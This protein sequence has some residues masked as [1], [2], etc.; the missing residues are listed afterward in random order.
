MECENCG[1]DGTYKGTPVKEG[2]YFV[3]VQAVG[4]DGIK[5]DI[6]SAVNLLRGYTEETTSK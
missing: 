1:W 5:Y 3:V 6:R 4:A 2:V